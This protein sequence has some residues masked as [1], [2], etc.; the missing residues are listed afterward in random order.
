MKNK[1][2]SISGKEILPLFS[3]NHGSYKGLLL[4]KEWK[5]KRKEILKKDN[6]KCKCCGSSNELQIHHRQYHYSLK[7]RRHRKPWE[8]PSLLL[9]TLCRKCHQKGHQKYKVP[10]IYI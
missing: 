4:S 7:L 1:K 8:Y 5:E 9:I 3:Y 2:N 6:Y 10:T